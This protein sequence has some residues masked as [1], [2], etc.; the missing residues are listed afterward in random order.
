MSDPKLVAMVTLFI[1]SPDQEEEQ[2][3]CVQCASLK[4]GLNK[5]GITFN[6]EFLD[7]PEGLKIIELA[8]AQGKQSAPLTRVIFGDGSFELVSGNNLPAIKEFFNV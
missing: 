1:K 5:A 4:R 8:K 7:S 6:T 2:G 3:R